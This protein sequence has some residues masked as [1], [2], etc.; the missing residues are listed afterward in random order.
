MITLFVIRGGG[1]IIINKLKRM[2]GIPNQQTK[3]ENDY[4]FQTRTNQIDRSNYPY[5]INIKSFSGNVNMNEVY[6]KY[7]DQIKPNFMMQEVQGDLII[8]NSHIGLNDDEDYCDGLGQLTFVNGNMI[9][10]HSAIVSLDKLNEVGKDVIIYHSVINKLGGLKQIGGNLEII[11]GTVLGCNFE[12][13]VNNTAGSTLIKWSQFNNGYIPYFKRNNRM[14]LTKHSQNYYLTQDNIAD[15]ASPE[16]DGNLYISNCKITDQ[17]NHIQ[18]INGDLILENAEI[19]SLNNLTS[20]GQNIHLKNS[21]IGY[22]N[23]LKNI[24]GSLKLEKSKIIFNQIEDIKGDILIS[25]ESYFDTR[26]LP[27]N[28]QADIFMDYNIC[29][30]QKNFFAKISGYQNNGTLT[31]PLPNTE[32]QELKMKKFYVN[33]IYSNQVPGLAPLDE[34]FKYVG[35][36]SAC[37]IKESKP[38]YGHYTDTR[39]LNTTM[40]ALAVY[41]N[42]GYF[43][44]QRGYYRHFGQLGAFV[45]KQPVEVNMHFDQIRTMPSK[46]TDVIEAK[47]VEEAIELFKNKKWRPFRPDIDKPPIYERTFSP[48]N[49]K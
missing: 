38:I 24:N 14:D 37:D 7:Y 42:E 11:G 29:D 36:F 22:L 12:E 3:K 9:L 34:K 21:E 41:Q 35:M 18:K 15:F 19:V 5:E 31:M 39:Y 49:E 2:F 43:C 13:L 46:D 20:L 6:S 44:P 4:L 10:R 45:S 27:N 47:S 8:E 33:T 1:N 40:H 23:N 25:S 28:Y 30:A 17:L 16:I 26:S 48:I 32:N